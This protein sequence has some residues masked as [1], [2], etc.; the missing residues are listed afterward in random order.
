MYDPTEHLFDS[1]DPMKKRNE[2]MKRMLDPM[3]DFN[4]SL[5]SMTS[6][7]DS[8][9]YAVDPMKAFNE[10]M[11]SITNPFGAYEKMMGYIADPM[12]KLNEQMESMVNPFPDIYKQIN[13]FQATSSLYSK[14][15]QE[16]AKS[17]SYLQNSIDSFAGISS[18]QKQAEL[19]A[20]S[21]SSY[22]TIEEAMSSGILGNILPTN[23]NSIVSSILEKEAEY[24]DI[25]DSQTVITEVD[26]TLLLQELQNMK[27]EILASINSKTAK[28]EDQLEAIYSHI[29]SIKNP[30]L[31][32]FFVS[33]IFPILMNILSSTLYDYKIKP[34]LAAIENPKQQQ[35]IIKKEVVRNVKF[36]LEDP[37]QRAK[38]RIVSTNVLNV[39][40]GNSKS[41]RTIAFT[42]F[43]EI[44]EIIRKEKN[45]CLI[46]RYDQE[47]ETYIQGW[48]FTRY[49][50]QIR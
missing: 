30:I 34:I 36:Y 6:I 44:V 32:A 28:I 20:S 3:Y 13:S 7:S 12:K 37:Q 38:Y 21:I 22:K 42:F 5:G 31:I 43:G 33:F 48:V 27:D 47:S 25:I 9:A 39:R 4:K 35:I 23:L 41:S 16:I 24:R 49:L 50:A 29:I 11:E 1:L 46:K 19:F 2:D 17:A 18:L 14:H 40:V 10:R 8:I 45:W 15:I 26:N